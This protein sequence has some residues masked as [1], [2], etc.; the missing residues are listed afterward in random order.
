[1]LTRHV[2]TPIDCVGK[3]LKFVDGAAEFV[4]RLALNKLWKIGNLVLR[5]SNK[6]REVSELLDIEE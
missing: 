1:M 6:T 4:A 5:A 2:G 3:T